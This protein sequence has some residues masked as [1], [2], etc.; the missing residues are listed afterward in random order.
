M[1]NTETGRAT[2]RPW[3]ITN[4]SSAYMEGTIISRG[5]TEIAGV[6]SEADAALIVKSVNHH[7][8]LV[9]LVRRA[10]D[11]DDPLVWNP[12]ARDLL[13]KIGATDG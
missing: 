3:E 2:A 7:D 8:E 13:T 6:W 11:G 4:E 10:L 12:Q 5:N 9:D 1:S